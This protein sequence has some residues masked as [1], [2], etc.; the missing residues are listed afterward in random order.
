MNVIQTHRIDSPLEANEIDLP[1]LTKYL[2]KKSNPAGM[3]NRNR[4]EI[5][6]IIT[7]SQKKKAENKFIKVSKW[8]I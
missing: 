7:H 2:G 4:M 3:K 5:F 1:D 8:G 6:V